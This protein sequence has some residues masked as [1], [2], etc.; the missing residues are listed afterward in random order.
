MLDPVEERVIPYDLARG[1]INVL[2]HGAAKQGPVELVPGD[3][4]GYKFELTRLA[5]ILRIEG[6]TDNIRLM[7][8]ITD[9]LGNVHRH[10]FSINT[11][12]WAY[13]ADDSESSSN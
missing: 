7:L 4:V 10:S 11:N 3:S 13:P 1:T 6:H 2:D 9:R 12:L 5:N 8:E